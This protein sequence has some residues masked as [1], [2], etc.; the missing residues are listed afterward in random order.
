M[1]GERWR[2][3]SP[4]TAMLSEL[5]NNHLDPGYAVA[6]E[7][8]RVTLPPSRLASRVTSYGTALVLLVTGLILA[9]AY[10][11]T[12]A[13]APDAERA[14]AGLVKEVKRES[15]A[16]DQ[17]QSDADQLREQVTR[18]REQAL[19]GS[20]T[21]Q[22]TA[23]QLRDLEIAAGL[24]PAVGP[25][26]AVTV[27]DGPPPTDPVTGEVTGD[28]DAGRVID[29]D[30]QDLVN[31]LWRAGAEAVAIDGQR[32]TPTSTI[33]LAGEA[34]LV[35]LKPVSNP[36]RIEAIGDPS[37]L[38]DRFTRSKLARDFRSYVTRYEMVFQVSSVSRL[39]VPAAPAPVLRYARAP[40]RA[41]KAPPSGSPSHPS[42]APSQ[43]RPGSSPTGG[44]R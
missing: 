26:L 42:A 13:R 21:G 22:Q 1:S 19:A 20:L 31:A 37:T 8:R 5:M 28:A 9:T 43:P 30:L 11:Q 38:D 41:S 3:S 15:T 36:Y 6:A 16:T 18:E 2:G 25:G 23:D 10:R 39:T 34:I 33:R 14:K 32:L 7:R 40:A 12:V 44:A 27:G 24:R 29:R 17:L 4:A 35:D